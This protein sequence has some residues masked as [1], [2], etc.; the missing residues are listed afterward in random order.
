MMVFKAFGNLF[1]EARPWPSV[2]SSLR[3]RLAFVLAVICGSS[4]VWII[5]SKK[6]HRDL[7]NDR[8]ES[9]RIKRPMDAFHLWI[10]PAKV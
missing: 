7:G 4:H 1:G 10:Q 6:K 5:A 3:N 8:S 2:E 9:K